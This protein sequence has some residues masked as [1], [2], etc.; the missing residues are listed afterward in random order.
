MKN[1]YKDLTGQKFGRLKVLEFIGKDK[2]KRA[3]WKCECECGNIKVVASPNLING[4]T[5]SCGC[6][7]GE[8]NRGLTIDSNGKSKK[9]YRIWASMKKRCQNKHSQDFK[10]YGGRGIKV[11]DE[12]IEFEPF[13]N[14]AMINGYKEGLTIERKDVNS[15]Y[16]P[17]NCIWIPFEEQAINRR[18]YT[19]QSGVRGVSWHK[20]SGKW[21]ARVIYHKK[22]VYAKLFP[23]L[24]DACEAVKRVREEIILG[25]MR[26]NGR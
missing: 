17:N 10:Y 4:Y 13:Y 16:E 8:M 9:I 6:L 21:Y 25:R 3:L 2:H 24:N 19:S 15:D 26:N 18:F 7:F 23:D 12:W 22:V 5:K 14:W 1:R 20:S 11:C